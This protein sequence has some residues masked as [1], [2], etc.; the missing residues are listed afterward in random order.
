MPRRWWSTGSTPDRTRIAKVH[1]TGPDL[2]PPGLGAPV[3]D[4]VRALGQTV[5]ATDWTNYGE[6]FTRRWVVDTILDA[7][8]YVPET[9]LSRVRLCEPSCGSGAF[10][11][12]VVERTKK[13]ASTSWRAHRLTTMPPRRTR[14]LVRC[15][16]WS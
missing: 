13:P 6:I 14:V 1:S 16:W 2:R 5:T 8:G 15:L 7:V 12:P 4:A 10:L 3:P 11:G 9:D